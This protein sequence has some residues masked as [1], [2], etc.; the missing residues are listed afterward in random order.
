M[1][2]GL[3]LGAWLFWVNLVTAVVCAVMT[4]GSIAVSS[5][6][7]AVVNA[8]G[9]V[10]TA[11]AAGFLWMTQGSCVLPQEPVVEFRQG[12]TLCPGQAAKFLT[13]IPSA[14]RAL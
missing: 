3:N 9:F 4:V 7:N 5:K 2:L 12:M 6:G 14:D 1:I 8:V 10:V 13:P 11:G